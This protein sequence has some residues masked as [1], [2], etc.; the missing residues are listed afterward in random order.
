MEE[1]TI[2]HENQQKYISTYVLGCTGPRGRP[3]ILADG[4]STPIFKN[5]S[6]SIYLS[7]Y[8]AIIVTVAKDIH[9]RF[10]CFAS[11]YDKNGGEMRLLF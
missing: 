5:K 1:K 10:G 11:R 2:M 9:V 3:A 4:R 7:I 8:K 6:L